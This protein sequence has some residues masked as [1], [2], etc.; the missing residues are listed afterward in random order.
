MLN[1]CIKLNFTVF[2]CFEYFNLL[3]HNFYT[4]ATSTLRNLILHDDITS[5]SKPQ[6]TPKN[7]KQKQNK[8]NILTNGT[9]CFS[10]TSQNTLKC[11]QNNKCS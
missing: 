5:W 8:Q 4:K 9:S 2:V 6:L 3:K 11:S 10:T 1:I 7:T